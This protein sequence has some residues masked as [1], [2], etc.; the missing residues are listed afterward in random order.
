MCFHKIRIERLEVEFSKW[1]LSIGDGSAP[2]EN[3]KN[4][5]YSVED[6]IYVD[7]SLLLTSDKEP[8][9]ELAK[10][11]YSSFIENYTSI[12]YLR[13]RAILSPHNDTI[14]IINAEILK[15]LLG[16]SHIYS[17]VDSVSNNEY[18]EGDFSFT[19]PIEYLN[20]LN[21][22]N[23]PQHKLHLKVNSV[24]M[25]IHNI[26]QRDGLCNG[27][28]LVITRLG[29]KIIEEQ[30]ITG[31]KS[32]KSILRPRIS[33]FQTEEKI[34]VTIRKKQFPIRL[35]FAITINKT[36]GQSLGRVDLYLPKPIFT[37]GQLYVALSRVTSLHGLKIYQNIKN[38][39]T[40]NT[41]CNIV[42]KEVLI[43]FK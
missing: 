37:R 6:H 3:S 22:S 15:W 43:I 36:Q 18:E 21:F 12:D 10:H 9:T 40:K 32:V 7:D 23:F 42:Y 17:S 11:V 1:I 31:H 8:I 34:P 19:Y 20:S 41:V 2:K 30:I 14:D 27:T 38:K 29:H 33:L 28:R 13:D 24:V 39:K 5:N 25:L 16:K 26:F 35:C 4:V